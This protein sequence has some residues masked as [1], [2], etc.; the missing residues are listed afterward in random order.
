MSTSSQLSSTVIFINQP[1]KNYIVSYSV[2]IHY[3]ERFTK[4]KKNLI[5]SSVLI[6]SYL[7]LN[8]IFLSQPT[9]FW[10][11]QKN[12]FPSLSQMI[13][14]EE[15][16]CDGNADT[17]LVDEGNSHLCLPAVNSHRQQFSSINLPRTILYL[18]LYWYTMVK[19]LPKRKKI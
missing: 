15:K 14:T 13:E 12:C 2:L 5:F 4:T 1:T 17:T 18:N 19:D 6:V 16:M 11:H 8:F 9:I 3:D 7:T 10:F